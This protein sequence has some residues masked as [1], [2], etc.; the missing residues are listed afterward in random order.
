MR[1][2]SPV[3]GPS[4]V[5]EAELRTPEQVHKKSSSMS[6]SDLSSSSAI[7]AA[8]DPFTD[9]D[10][11]SPTASR[12]SFQYTAFPGTVNLRGPNGFVS[13]PV[14]CLPT[15]VLGPYPAGY[16]QT[17][18]TQHL[19]GWG[20][21]AMNLYSSRDILA[22]QNPGQHQR[23]FSYNFGNP[24]MSQIMPYMSPMT[25]SGRGDWRDH[26]SP[27]SRRSSWT[28]QHYSSSDSSLNLGEQ[29][30]YQNPHLSATS[31]LVAQSVYNQAGGQNL[32]T[33]NAIALAQVAQQA[34]LQSGS[35][36]ASDSPVSS[37]AFP[38]S[39]TR[40]S[41][42]ASPEVLA[43]IAAGSPIPP[44]VPSLF[45]APSFEE[46]LENS[47]YNPNNTTN[48][49]IRGLP[50]DT[51]DASLVQIC[52]RF[53]EIATS[54][55][56]VDAQ[57]NTCKGFG[58]ACFVKEGDATLCIAGL[59][60]YGYQVSFAKESFSTRLKNLQD[61]Q[62]T[63]L[64]LSN[65]PLSMHEKVKYPHSV[66]TW[67][68]DQ[69]LEELFQPYK[70]VSNRILRDS[71]NVSRG[72]G[73]ARMCDRES[74]EAIIAK[75]DNT[76]VAGDG[77]GL[78]LQIRFADSPSQKRLKNQTQKRRLWRAREY[79]ILTGKMSLDEGHFELSPMQHMPGMMLMNP[80]SGVPYGPINTSLLQSYPPNPLVSNALSSDLYGNLVQPRIMPDL[81]AEVKVSETKQ[82]A[83]ATEEMT[84]VFGSGLTI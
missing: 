57:T 28:T 63:N 62:S 1:D 44:P 84:K 3:S 66:L 18:Y 60:H 36:Y 59:I 35:R 21:D 38:S 68:T 56:I 23:R 43:K 79:N 47:L 49:Y 29:Q 24:Q 10:T 2:A 19:Q 11:G 67:L 37:P 39:P 61:P 7:V 70:V 64:Y 72:V 76:P 34:A 69:D 45:A 55:A 27:R 31:G 8:S 25:L 26:G 80:L 74:A 52:E 42:E 13:Q 5:P 9:T 30:N 12:K 46:A 73:F 58:F 82:S 20:H 53:G 22:A 75:F 16:Y 41:S 14:G 83:K 17:G 65:L 6:S 51:T 78:S 54:K 81:A 48:V 50:P 71:N 40:L 4:T 77:S 32:N 33:A 15:Q